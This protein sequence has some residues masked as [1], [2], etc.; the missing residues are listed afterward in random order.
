MS[1]YQ[2]Y[3]FLAIDRPLTDDEY[4]QVRACSSRAEINRT[5]FVNE[6]QWGDFRGDP[7]ALM[8]R[9]YDAHLYFANWGTRI[10]MLRLPL[11]LLGLETAE[12]YC[13]DST[14]FARGSGTNLILDLR[15][16]D[17]EGDGWWGDDDGP[18]SLG[19]LAVLRS[20][21]EAGDLRPLYLAWLAALGSVDTA[22]PW[23]DDDEDTEDAED[24]LEPPVPNGL[25]RLT[26]AQ[27]ALADFLRVD[28]DLIEASAEGSSAVG[29][30]RVEVGP[31]M[32]DVWIR[33][34]TTKQK[35]EALRRLLSDDDPL[36]RAEMRRA[37]RPAPAAPRLDG[38]RRTV[39]SLF[40][41]A[42]GYAED[43]QAALHR[44]EAK[45]REELEEQTRREQE[46]RLT[47]LAERGERAWQEVNQLVAAKT[48]SS[49]A[50]AV[51]LLVALETLSRRGGSP[52]AFARRVA[53]LRSTHQ[54]KPAFITRLDEAGLP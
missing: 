24:I 48:A 12:A 31:E 41:T 4:E 49:Y 44:L 50:A 45:R 13:N 28:R 23:E 3:E 33:S 5:R 11:T 30:P 19:T 51:K 9:F 39:A 1:E 35:D 34:L 43:R 40:R 25:S 21:L 7:A 17:E 38:P 46:E 47:A 53:D 22:A 16:E 36:A 27:H 10:L 32:L 52:S 54:R 8:D 29:V 14:V 26:P 37:A 6:Y 20:E 42:A 15:S 18:G 2:Y